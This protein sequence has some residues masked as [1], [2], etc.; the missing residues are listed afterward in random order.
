MKRI[1]ILIFLILFLA[2]PFGAKAA[3]WYVKKT[4]TDPN[5]CNGGTS[6][7][8]AFATIQKA[9]EC[10]QN[11][12]EIWVAEGVYFSNSENGFQLQGD[13]ALY[14]GFSGSETRRDQRDWEAHKTILSGDMDHNDIDI[15]GDGIIEPSDGDSIQGTN[16]IH[17]LKGSDYAVLDGFIITAGGSSSND[18][19]GLY[20]DTYDYS[21]SIKNCAFVGNIA[22]QGGAIYINASVDVIDNCVFSENFAS[23]SGG[24]IYLYS[25][26]ANVLDSVFKDNSA[27][28]VGGGAISINDDWMSIKNSIFVNNS[29]G[30]DYTYGGAIYHGGDLLELI[31]CVLTNNAAKTSGGAIFN[32]ARS[33]YPYSTSGEVQVINSILWNNSPNEI[34]IDSGQVT[35]SHSDVK[36]CGGSGNWDYNCGTDSGG[37]IDTDPLFIDPLNYDFHLQHGS[38]CIDIGDNNASELPETD[39]EGDPR[40]LNGSNG[41]MSI[42]DMGVDEYRPETLVRYGLNVNLSGSGTGTVIIYP[43]G[44]SCSSDC[45]EQYDDT[46]M[47]N[48]YAAP[49]TDEGYVFKGWTGDCES[50]GYN[51]SCS[52]QMYKDTT[53]IAEFGSPDVLYVKPNGTGNCAS[54]DDACSLS[55]ALNRAIPKINEIW[56]AEG[57]YYGGF[58]LK[59]NV[60]LY[61]GFSGDETGRDQRDWEAHKTIL[62]GDMGHNDIDND[63]DGVIEPSDGDSIQ[64]NNA[65]R[66]LTG[67]NEARIDGFV[68]TAGDGS[69]GGGLHNESSNMIVANSIFVGNKADDAG[70]AIYNSGTLTILNTKFLENESGHYYFYEGGGAIYNYNY[71]R[72]T[73]KDS[74][75]SKNKTTEYLAKGG[76]IDNA[77]YARLD[78]NNCKF[79]KNSSYDVGGGIYFYNSWSSNVRN[80]VFIE[81]SA[82][83][84]AGIYNDSSSP[85]V[86]NSIFI[87]NVLTDSMGSG[88]A[89]YNDYSWPTIT[90]CSFVGHVNSVLFDYGVGSN[91]RNSIFW[92][93]IN[94]IEIDYSVDDEDDAPSIKYSDIRNG[95]PGEG[96]INDEPIFVDPDNGNLHLKSDSPCIDSGKNDFVSQEDTD[97][98]GDPRIM[99]G[100]GDGISVV[101][102]GA[103]EFL[104]QTTPKYLLTLNKTGD[105]NGSVTSV[106]SGITCGNDC[107]E[108][109]DSGTSVTL[110][111][112]PDDNSLFNGW[113]GACAMCEGTT[114]TITMDAD[115]T[116]TA[117]FAPI[118]NEPPVIQTLTAEPVSGYTPLTVSF[119]CTAHD[120][121]GSILEY[122]WDFNGDN[123]FDE[124]TNTGSTTYTYEAP[125]TH[126]ARCKVVDDDGAESI[127]D[128][129]EITAQA[130]P[131]LYTLSINPVPDHGSVLSPQDGSQI[132]CGSAGTDCSESYEDG[133][134]I[135]LY[136]E[137]DEGYEFAG[138]VGYCASC[139]NDVQCAIQMDSDKTCTA[140]FEPIPNEP[141]ILDSF[142]AEPTSGDAPLDVSFTCEA[143]DLDGEIVSYAWDFDG[144]GTVDVTSETG[145]ISH[146]YT[147]PGTYHPTCTVTDD[148]GQSVTS[149]SQ[150]I[151]VNEVASSW[152]DITD[153]LD[154]THSA[155]QLYDRIHRC[156][157]I[158]V[159][160]ENPGEE[161]VSGPVRLVITDPSIPVNTGV[162]VGLEP[163]GYTEEGNPYFIIVPEEGTLDAG[164]VLRNLRINFELQRKRLTYGIR[165]EQ[166]GQ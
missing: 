80:S 132:T 105:G 159:T 73:I 46:T 158:Q 38:P 106:P 110:T 151:T 41:Q 64:G 156:F 115:K 93:D 137:P 9:L 67:A 102:M 8:T 25:G 56:V 11:Y 5:N 1:R 18:G 54:W 149:G 104:L 35:V 86:S 26:N 61:G 13:V 45:S 4:G 20:I 77:Y 129:V 23:Y 119:T 83:F 116:C 147:D 31:N 28:L 160:V 43:G 42:V 96:N 98:D 126:E 153:S 6:W 70:G 79:E 19:G 68:V 118:P 63:G 37:N 92:D 108:E 100:D 165:I 66:V 89:I 52:S 16:S 12:D 101:D 87:K 136:A 69:Y 140:N 162:G 164:A 141:P 65:Y 84:G 120:S 138:W 95:F 10:A 48:L 36:N 51:P 17:V 124:T 88:S 32:Y 24:A 109:F 91:V 123:V 76:A 97:I 166:L 128:P 33:G 59:E 7:Q 112:V 163:D 40:I 111:A 50:C 135:I 113:G 49:D 139:G 145:T 72:M 121:D 3:V 47:V 75:F 143:R 131:T 122:Q 30:S 144:D 133:T 90:N 14:G 125:G 44:E 2:V 146:T 127:S 94:A 161:A 34:Y 74:F 134:G 57:I 39:F 155:R 55:E 22:S 152:V 99:D 130:Q 85:D 81:N 58:Q 71:G 53:C 78:I 157:F 15:D 103:D 82:T 148:D 21:M 150:E 114:C 60:A 142:T 27:E 117:N 107:S 154:I 62:S 29:T